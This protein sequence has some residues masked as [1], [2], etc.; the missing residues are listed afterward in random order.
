MELTH[1]DSS[2]TVRMVDVT[3]KN[4]THRTASAAGR[5]R[6]NDECFNALRRGTL[7]KGDALTAAK[8]AGIMAAKRTSELIP[9]CHTI[10]LTHIDVTARLSDCDSAVDVCCYVSCDGKTGAEMEALTGCTTAL[11]TVYDMCKALDRAMVIENIHL[12]EKTGGKSGDYT[13]S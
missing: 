11:L 10:T 3:D 1:I 12:T 5:I 4:V 6:M 8:I 2:G 7:K 13:Q 9:L